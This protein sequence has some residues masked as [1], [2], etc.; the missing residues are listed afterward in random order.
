MSDPVRGSVSE[1]P[2]GP[3]YDLDFRANP[4]R[5]RHTPDER[6]AF[7]IEP[8]KSQLLPEWG[9]ATLDDAESGAEAI[10]GRYESY[11]EGDDFVGMDIARKYLQMGWTRAMRYAKYPGGQKYERD[12]DGTRVERE[13]REWYDPEKREIALVYREYSRP[14][15]RG[16]RVRAGETPPPRAVRGVDVARAER[17]VGQ[18]L[19]AGDGHD[20]PANLD[21]LAGRVDSE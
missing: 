19:P 9:I 16:P 13:P 18:Q 8:Y 12:E 2:D 6:G 15:A 5:Y 3:E 11:R 7:K 20:T 1:V 14:G 21:C 10:Y 4:G 17:S